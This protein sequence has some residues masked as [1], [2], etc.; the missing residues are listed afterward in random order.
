MQRL[1]VDARRRAGHVLPL[2]AAVLSFRLIPARAER[3]VP[4]AGE[5]DCPHRPIGPRQQESPGQYID[6]SEERRV[7]QECVSTG[8][9]RWST[10][11][12]NNKTNMREVTSLY[13]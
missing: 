7:G 12:L 3:P 4:R 9:S 5:D 2:V 8:R 13:S 6:R 1:D 10:D 11:L